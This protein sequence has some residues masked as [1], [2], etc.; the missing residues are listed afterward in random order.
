MRL[1]VHC[2][3]EHQ[4]P[5]RWHFYSVY[6]GRYF[7]SILGSFLLTLAAICTYLS[8]LDCVFWMMSWQLLIVK[9]LLLIVRLIDW[10]CYSSLENSCITIDSILTMM[11]LISSCLL[12]DFVLCVHVNLIFIFLLQQMLVNVHTPVVPVIFCR[13]VYWVSRVKDFLPVSNYF[14]PDI[15]LFLFLLSRPLSCNISGWIIICILVQ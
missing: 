13:L 5:H 8:P 3:P 7:F 9:C 14:H 2:G 12:L 15:F 10:S 1:F 4:F 11:L 6:F